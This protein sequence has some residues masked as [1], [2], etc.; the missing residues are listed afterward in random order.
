MTFSDCGLQAKK[1]SAISLILLTDFMPQSNPNAKN[2]LPLA[3]IY[4]PGVPETLRDP[5]D[6]LVFYP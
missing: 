6:K 3:I 4:N 2:I 5:Y 1:K